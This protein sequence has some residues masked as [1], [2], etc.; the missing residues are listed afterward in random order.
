MFDRDNDKWELNRLISSGTLPS[1]HIPTKTNSRNDMDDDDHQENR[2]H[3]IAKDVIPPFLSGWS[4]PSIK[5][6]SQPSGITLPVRDP[7]SDMAL[8]S[9]KG[10]AL[11]KAVRER[12]E[13]Q[14]A[15][16][17]LEGGSTFLGKI[18]GVS[19]G[20]QD[21]PLPSESS[22]TQD[23]VGQEIA[24]TDALQQSIPK[25]AL[26]SLKG[27][28]T[29]SRTKT[30][31]EQREFLPAFS[32]RQELLRVIREHSIV[33]IVGETG[34]GKTTQLTQYLHEDGYSVHGIIGCTQP[35]RVA[36]MSVAKRVSE[37]MGSA[38]GN[39]V[40]YA[41]RFEDVT[42]P[43]TV[44]KCKKHEQ[45]SIIIYYM[46]MFKGIYLSTCRYD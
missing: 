2:A 18:R 33:I 14:K 3:L 44:I 16:R 1:N 40:G 26:L 34:S 45:V 7:T 21:E 42:S 6:L 19:N 22:D 25:D 38:L 8:F 35:R 29:F 9:R 11:V 15:M 41:I 24:A 10:S 28:S 13:R 12:R 46:H 39:A 36:A 27:A 23:L 30:I 17:T 20:I 4:L 32:V 37:E 5:G 43:S 31:K